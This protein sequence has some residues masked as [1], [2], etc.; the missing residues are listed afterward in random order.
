MF[1]S[2]SLYGSNPSENEYENQ[3]MFINLKEPMGNDTIR[4][5]VDYSTLL[6]IL[7]HIDESL[8][9]N[10]I[11]DFARIGIYNINDKPRPLVV[12]FHSEIDRNTV[13]LNALKL[14]SCPE[15][16]EISLEV[17]KRPSTV[18]PGN[19]K[20][21][22]DV[23]NERLNTMMQLI[24][25]L[26]KQVE[27]LSANSVPMQ[28]EQHIHKQQMDHLF[29]DASPQ[30]S[31]MQNV[32]SSSGIP[33]HMTSQ[34][35]SF[36]Q[37]IFQHPQNSIN[38]AHLGRSNASPETQNLSQTPQFFQMPNVYRENMPSDFVFK[39]MHNQQSSSQSTQKKRAHSKI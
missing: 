27:Q 15:W 23:I 37:P 21:D 8:S 9:I 38:G 34:Q 30:Y 5:S 24:L 16:K 29:R 22:T 17:R 13:I 28:Q 18:Q 36:Q 19:H 7:Y 2:G 4:K 14:K 32:S 11:K 35:P 31:Y 25:Q 12:Q 39:Q 20:S 26:G 6:Q 1:N 33:F 3:I 10:S